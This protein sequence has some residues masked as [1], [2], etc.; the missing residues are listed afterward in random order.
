MVS[1]CKTIGSGEGFN[2]L[3]STWLSF[4]LATTRATRIECLETNPGQGSI[5]PVT[6]SLTA[7]TF[8]D[9]TISCPPGTV[10]VSTNL[11]YHMSHLPHAYTPIETS[12]FPAL[13]KPDSKSIRQLFLAKKSTPIKQS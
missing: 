5:I 4:G 12:L 11:P 7:P 2:N 10:T 3:T 9:M 13:T 1:Q 6:S 8:A